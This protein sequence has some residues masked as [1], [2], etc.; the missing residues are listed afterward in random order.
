MNDKI[1]Y[2]YYTMLDILT[3]A[4]IHHLNFNQSIHI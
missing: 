2:T 3:Q 1:V 4:L